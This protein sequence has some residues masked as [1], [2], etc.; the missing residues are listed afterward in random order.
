MFC[1]QDA[2]TD[3][4]GRS[5]K[6]GTETRNSEIKTEGTTQRQ[7]TEGATLAKVTHSR[8]TRSPERERTTYA[9]DDMLWQEGKKDTKTLHSKERQT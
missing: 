9:G 7:D 1:T 8:I 5:P 4:H 6:N 3:A 2:Q